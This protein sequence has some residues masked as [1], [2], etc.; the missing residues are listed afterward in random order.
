MSALFLAKAWRFYNLLL[1]LLQRGLRKACKA[2]KEQQS[3]VQSD[4]G[5]DASVLPVVMFYFYHAIEPRQHL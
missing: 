2:Q 1:F 3:L 4:G 5:M